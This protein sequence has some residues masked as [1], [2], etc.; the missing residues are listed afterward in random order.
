MIQP[1]IFAAVKRRENCVGSDCASILPNVKAEAS[2]AEKGL[3]IIFGTFAAVAVIVIIV[4]AI[5]LAASEGNPDNIARS[6]KTIIYAL[7]GLIIAL[8]AE[9]LVLTLLG[10]F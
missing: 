9:A 2:Q 5:N 7:I 4:A 8:S 1:L 6:K 10:R 3:A